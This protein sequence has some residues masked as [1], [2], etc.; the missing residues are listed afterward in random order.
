MVEIKEVLVLDG[1][2]L[3]EYEREG[4]KIIRENIL[5]TLKTNKN[6]IPRIEINKKE[7]EELSIK[8]AETGVETVIISG[9]GFSLPP[10]IAME[11]IVAATQESQTKIY[12]CANSFE[13]MISVAKS[14]NIGLN[15]AV[16]DKKLGD[17]FRDYFYPIKFDITKVRIKSVEFDGWGQRCCIDTVYKMVEGEG[18]LVYSDHDDKARPSYFL[19][20]G[21]T[22]TTEFT[23]QRSFR[24]NAGP[25]CNYA[26]TDKIG[27]DEVTKYLEELKCGSRVLIVDK[28][29]NARRTVVGRNKMEERTFLKVTTEIGSHILLQDA[30]PVYLT[31]K[32]GKPRSVLS[33]RSGNKILM[34]VSE[35]GMHGGR[36]IK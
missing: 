9:K 6:V 1:T 29:G 10:K 25:F 32:N 36:K 18:M 5:E 3:E 16:K 7:D 13:E 15:V 27:E 26:I 30:D 12:A 4:K 17:I 33:L 14:L 21:E 22:P 20:H 31:D 19:V 23:P 34:Y 11:N 8:V 28:N 24:A 2:K 35:G